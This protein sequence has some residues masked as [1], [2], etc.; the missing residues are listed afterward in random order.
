[1]TVLEKLSAILNTKSPEGLPLFGDA[2]GKDATSRQVVEAFNVLERLDM[3]RR[4]AIWP[5]DGKIDFAKLMD[6]ASGLILTMAR[7][8]FKEFIEAYRTQTGIEKAVSDFETIDRL[9]EQT[10]LLRERV[11]AAMDRKGID[12]FV[13]EA[14]KSG[15]KLLEPVDWENASGVSGWKV[16]MEFRP[17]GE[18]RSEM[19]LSL[20]DSG[21]SSALLGNKRSEMRLDIPKEAIV[22]EGRLGKVIDTRKLALDPGQREALAREIAALEAEVIS[23]PVF[24]KEAAWGD[25]L[26]SK[27]HVLL[28]R[29][30]QDVLTGVIWAWTPA[31]EPFSKWQRLVVKKDGIRGKAHF[32]ADAYLSQVFKSGNTKILGDI[33]AGESNLSGFLEEYLKR[34]EKESFFRRGL[35]SNRELLFHLMADPLDPSRAKESYWYERSDAGERKTTKPLSPAE[36]KV[37]RLTQDVFAF[38]R[39]SRSELRQALALLDPVAYAMNRSEAR[40]EI[41]TLLTDPVKLESGKEQVAVIFKGIPQRGDPILQILV[42][43][44]AKSH[45]SFQIAVPGA[46][47]VELGAFRERLVKE[48]NRARAVKGGV[49]L[50]VASEEKDIAKFVGRH[51]ENALVYDMREGEAA[52]VKLVAEVDK[53]KTGKE[54]LFVYNDQA[55]ALS[56]RSFALLAAINTLLEN[57]IPKDKKIQK[58]SD[59]LG[60]FA[61]NLR[62]AS[63]IRHENRL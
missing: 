6:P 30:A 41:E 19:H 24:G 5:S 13:A 48:V 21:T 27:A 10:G 63:N 34:G 16:S 33:Y 49:N 7:V 57:K 32:L 60:K 15:F 52:L 36:L 39:V 51:P 44:M 42:D 4:E 58:G 26:K 28:L 18:F 14:G 62:I 47:R 40:V 43:G 29:D 17:D 46:A 3:E 54:T 23:N 11:R 61:E 31:G 12:Q 9:M 22:A 56:Q 38:M 2:F 50:E 20:V 53:A 55:L 37:A 45:L 25:H 1:M 35:V 8:S 59:V